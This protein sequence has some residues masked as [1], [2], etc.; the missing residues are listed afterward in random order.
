MIQIYTGDGKGKTTAALGQAL[1]ALGH[2]HKV[3]M[4]QFLKG[5]TYGEL[6]TC[7]NCLPDFSIVMYGRD[8][9]VKKGA[10]EEIDVRMARQGFE[11]ARKVAAEGKHQMLI[12]DEINIAVDYGLI[13]LSELLD[14]LDSCPRDMEVVCTGRYAPP[15]LIEKADL[16]SEVKEI[17]HHYQRGVGMRKGIEY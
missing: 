9:F 3:F 17:K 11:L 4:I 15:E 1:R 8:D 16:V 2:G 6:I 13:S 12:L 14:F 10:P 7:K 5:R